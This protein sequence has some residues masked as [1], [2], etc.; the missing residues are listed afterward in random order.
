[1]K[2]VSCMFSGSPR[3][4]DYLCEDDTVRVGDNAI[5][6][7][8]RGDAAVI[9]VAVKDHSDRATAHIK[10]LVKPDINTLF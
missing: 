4:Y 2:I 1:M 6:E 3:E 7:T 8:R 10:R 5:V 9:V